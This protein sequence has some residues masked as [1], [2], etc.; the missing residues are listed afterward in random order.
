MISRSIDR[1]S[2]HKGLQTHRSM[3][4]SESGSELVP[5]RDERRGR[6]STLWE[7][8][9]D[10]FYQR[11]VIS[12]KTRRITNFCFQNNDYC[13]T[14]SVVGAHTTRHILWCI[15]AGTGWRVFFGDRIPHTLHLYAAYG[16][17]PSTRKEKVGTWF[18]YVLLQKKKSLCKC[19]HKFQHCW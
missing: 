14:E 8:T 12:L 18:M 7:R 11:R 1:K 9:A 3:Q 15:G 4:S 5:P 19:E 17:C 6:S 16:I 10:R 2:G 13:V